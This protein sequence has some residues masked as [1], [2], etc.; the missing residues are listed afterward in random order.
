MNNKKALQNFAYPEKNSKLD[1]NR[2]KILSVKSLFSGSYLIIFF[3]LSGLLIR[4]TG[5]DAFVKASIIL[6]RG[7]A[8][9]ASG[10]VAGPGLSCQH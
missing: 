1:F 2:F 8:F 10:M 4:C 9:C 3:V 5:H 6:Q 7:D